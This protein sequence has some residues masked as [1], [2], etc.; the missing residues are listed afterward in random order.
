MKKYA[1]ISCLGDLGGAQWHERMISAFAQSGQTWEVIRP[2]AA[3]F[4]EKA[5]EYS[6]HVISGGPMSVVDDAGQPA[7]KNLLAFVRAAAQ[8]GNVPVVGLCLG[9]QII[10]VAL[11]GTVGKNPSGRFKL[12][13]DRLQWRPQAR[14]LLG[15]PIDTAAATLLV[16]S[17]GECVLTLPAGAV[18]L[19]SSRTIAHEVFLIQGQF[20]GIQGHPEADIETLRKTF[21]VYH[22]ARFNEAQW[23]IVEQEAQQ[24]PDPSRVIALGRRLLNAGRLPAT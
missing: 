1:V 5:F 19:A 17:H 7:M 18:A 24:I 8:R 10:A 14:A 20:L 6:G 15:E 23:T 9:A 13:V 16:Q 3:G 21:M 12:G 22:R 4:I 11:G 2:A